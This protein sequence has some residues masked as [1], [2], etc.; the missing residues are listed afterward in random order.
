M[1][2]NALENLYLYKLTNYFFQYSRLSS[3]LF[4][5]FILFYSCC[6][7]SRV[8]EKT[9]VHEFP[10]SYSHTERYLL[11]SVKQDLFEGRPSGVHYLPVKKRTII[12]IIMLKYSIVTI[13]FVL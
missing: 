4:F 8:F 12:K 6:S 11:F 13:Y 2:T 9:L 1:N 3:Y 5:M 7:H 10:I